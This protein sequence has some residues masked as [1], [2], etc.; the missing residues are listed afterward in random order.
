[1][2]V[3]FIVLWAG[4]HRLTF[5]IWRRVERKRNERKVEVLFLT[6]FNRIVAIKTDDEALILELAVDFL[7]EKKYSQ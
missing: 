7:T 4:S 5:F 3:L 6:A 1:M 2:Y